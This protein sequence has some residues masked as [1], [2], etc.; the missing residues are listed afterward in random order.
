MNKYNFLA[1]SLGFKGSLTKNKGLCTLCG[2]K[3]N[4]SD[5]KIQ[6]SS[7][8][9]N[10]DKLNSKSNQVCSSCEFLL[11]KMDMLRHGSFICFEDEFIQLKHENIATTLFSKKR[12]PFIF[13]VNFSFQKHTIFTC[14]LNYDD[15]N[16]VIGTDDGISI[17]FDNSKYEPL[18]NLMKDMYKTFN[19]AELEKGCNNLKK[20]KEYGLGKY[21]E[22][23]KVLEPF[24]KDYVLKILLFI[25]KGD[26][27]DENK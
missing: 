22:H 20:I 12:L 27:K 10:Y 26:K 18:F 21:L 1:K 3:D 15:N 13:S 11:T 5:K 19:K 9:T 14:E 2:N 25:L 8:F 24:R 7:S 16:F 4:I 23:N 17:S 6:L